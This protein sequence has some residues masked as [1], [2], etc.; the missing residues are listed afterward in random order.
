MEFDGF[1]MFYSMYRFSLYLS[2]LLVY[3][4]CAL[5]KQS[6]AF[7]RQTNQANQF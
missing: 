3:Y 2:D 7:C 6:S 1:F 5:K 4:L